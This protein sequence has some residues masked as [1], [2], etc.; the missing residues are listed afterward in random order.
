MLFSVVFLSYLPA[1]YSVTDFPQAV[2]PSQR[3]SCIF[4]C[5]DKTVTLNIPKASP[6]FFALSLCLSLSLVGRQLRM[7]AR[8]FLPQN[9][10]RVAELSSPT[11]LVS[12]P[13]APIHLQRAT[14][15]EPLSSSHYVRFPFQFSFA[16]S[17]V[18]CKRRQAVF[19]TEDRVP[20]W[21]CQVTAYHGN[22]SWP[23]PPL[24]EAHP[25]L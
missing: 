2:V 21:S 19:S 15:F 23:P 3:R 13:Y 12:D 8:N 20:F 6:S 25:S 4:L 7:S 18:K 24:L 10:F 9:K 22:F 14:F 11:H 16:Y 17:V 5:S 1:Q